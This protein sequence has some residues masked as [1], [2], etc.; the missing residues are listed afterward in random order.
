MNTRTAKMIFGMICLMDS[1]YQ[2][3]KQKSVL[4]GSNLY[5]RNFKH[6]LREFEEYFKNS[7]NRS[8]EVYINGE[9]AVLIFQDHSQSNNKDLSDDKY[10]IAEN[11]TEIAVGDYV[12]W[13]DTEW[14]VFTEEYKTIPTHQQL[15]VKHV[16]EIVRWIQDGKVV[17][18][19]LGYGAYVQSQTLYTMGVKVVPSMEIVDSK[20]SMYMQNNEDT[21]KIQMN[22]RLFVGRR[23]YKVKFIDDV[24]RPGLISYLLD[25]DRIGVYDNVKM[26]VTDYYRYYD[27]NGQLLDKPI[28]EEKFADENTEEENLIPPIEEIIAVIKGESKPKI[29]RS[30]TYTS[31]VDVE[32][33]SIDYMTTEQ[34]CYV[35]SKSEKEFV[36][37]FKDNFKLVGSKINIMAKRKDNGEYISY[38]LSIAKKY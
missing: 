27:N 24:S 37:Q 13:S 5:E 17:N 36:V 14:L 35:I 34:P 19:G 29:S 7:L 3:F 32:E 8:E 22:D 26:S 31:S 18:N 10:V 21:L 15:K 25:E 38:P 9:P 20:M 16:N 28:S 33:W 6:K 4:R 2:T 12:T 1:I 11:S 23:V 30:Y